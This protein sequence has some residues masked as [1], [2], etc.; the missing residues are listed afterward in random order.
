MSAEH[1]DPAPT[2]P[3]DCSWPETCDFPACAEYRDCSASPWA[4]CQN[5]KRQAV[6]L[7][8]VEE[9]EPWK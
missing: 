8:L 3:T 1:P 2:A 4:P 5:P 9:Q 6:E 7:K